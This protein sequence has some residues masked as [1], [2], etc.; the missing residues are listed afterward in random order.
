VADCRGYSK[1]LFSLVNSL[2]GTQTAR[3][4]PNRYSDA[5]AAAELANFFET[6]VSQIRFGL[7][8]AADDAG[9][10]P[11]QPHIPAPVAD[12]STRLAAIHQLTTDDVRELPS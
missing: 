3:A 4:V 2:M 11:I 7:G 9:L 10:S 8:T 1:K 5:V 6:K 12:P